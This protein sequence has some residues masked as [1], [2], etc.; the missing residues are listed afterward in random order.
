MFP[1]RTL[2]VACF[3]M[4]VHVRHELLFGLDAVS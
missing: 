2:E 4:H 3:D 1:R